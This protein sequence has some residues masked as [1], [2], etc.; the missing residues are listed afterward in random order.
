MAFLLIVIGVIVAVVVVALV[1]LPSFID[2]SQIIALAQ[3]QV[4]KATGGELSV[5]GETQL[6]LIPQIVI[7]LGDTTI[8]LPPQGQDS[9]RILAEVGTIDIGISPWSLLMGDTEV[10]RIALNNT[11]VTLFDVDGAVATQ[12]TLK[13]I[14]AEGLNTANSPMG[15]RAELALANLDGGEPIVVTMKG[16]VRVPK[17]VDRISIDKLQTDVDG[18][19]TERIRTTLSG[20]VMLSPL[21]ATLDLVANLPGGDIDGDLVYAAQ[22]SPQIDL[23]FSSEQLDLDKISPVSST[24]ETDTAQ[25]SGIKPP[26][27]PVP[28]GPLR[29]LDMRLA[30]T[31]NS[32]ISN[33]QEITGAQLLMRVVN[34]VSDLKY[35]RGVL[36]GGQ[37]DT[38]MV[39]DARKP[40]IEVSLAGGLSGFNIDSLMTSL[41]SPDTAHGRVDMTWDVDTQGTTS[42]DLKL[43]LDGDVNVTGSNVEILS[44]SAQGEMCRAIAQVNAESLTADMPTTTKVTALGGRIAF[45]NG[46]AQLKTFNVATPGLV[47]QGSGAA[48]LDDLTFALTV[49]ASVNKELEELD[50]A[51]RIEERYIAVKWP[52]QCSGNLMGEPSEWCRIDTDSIVKQMLQ[53]EAKSKLQREADKLGRDAGK[54]LKKLFGN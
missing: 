52:V 29:D 40:V 9:G 35:L 23:T 32:L 42:E 1:V 24:A 11:E 5:E 36:H 31:A 19:L 38:N 12:L 20:T 10:G 39:I 50:R 37:L 4:R 16:T 33:G 22:Q 14:V 21:E 25:D 18:A 7:V 48:S 2:E 49:N 43:G 53:Y 3:E 27:I 13:E 28:V 47:M 15:L 17:D 51:C 46:Q 44:V 41:D 26:P 54:A 6:S 34:G 8:D 30:V 45:D